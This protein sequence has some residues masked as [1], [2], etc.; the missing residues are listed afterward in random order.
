MAVSL[1]LAA[2]FIR[3]PETGAWSLV[4]RVASS[5][6]IGVDLF[7]VL[8]GFLITGILL[9]SRGNRNYFRSFYTRRALR[10]LPLYYSFI[11]FILLLPRM[12]ALA[13]WL[14]ASYLVKHQG[15]FWS[16]TVNWLFVGEATHGLATG[17]EQGFGALWSLAIEEQFY[18]IWPLIVALIP[19]R[20]LLSTIGGIAL[21]CVVLRV[22]LAARGVPVAALYGV[23]LTRLDGLSVGAALAVLQREGG[24]VRWWR[25]WAFAVC[26]CALALAAATPFIVRSTFSN[27]LLFS[28]VEFP[29]AMGF[30]ALLM[31]A[32]ATSSSVRAVMSAR[33]LCML[34][35]YSYAIYVL[36]AP[37]QHVMVG[38][39]AGPERISFPAFM[40]AGISITLGL[41]FASWH[42]WEVH[43]L[44]LRR[45]GPALARPKAAS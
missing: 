30:G 1:V 35:K 13:E 20:R 17:A 10:I 3:S 21:G 41:A 44:R 6:W 7:F 19:R 4:G 29:I 23:T 43:F 11:A 8:S 31:M 32:V 2:H 15:W 28:A 24:L 25:P 27:A 26:G 9:D 14:G 39:G 5:G 42:L 37:V 18:L 45:Y 36:Q 33:P 12:S 16:Y 38:A 34:G 40:I 22:V